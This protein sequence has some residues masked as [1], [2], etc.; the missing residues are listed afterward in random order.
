MKSNFFTAVFC[1]KAAQKNKY[2]HMKR[3]NQRVKLL[4]AFKVGTDFYKMCQY[5]KK[6]QNK[7]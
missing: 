6:N 3:I 2:R 4:F 5:Y 1:K 7:F